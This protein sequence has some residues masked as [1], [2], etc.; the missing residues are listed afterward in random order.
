MLTYPPAG[1]NII[2][3]ITGNRRS[4]YRRWKQRIKLIDSTQF[5]PYNFSAP[6]LFMSFFLM[7]I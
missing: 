1:G 6:R 5:H 2:L 3:N 4:V 7:P